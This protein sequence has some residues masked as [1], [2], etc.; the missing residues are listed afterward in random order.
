MLGLQCE[1]QTRSEQK[2][3]W[4]P[5]RNVNSIIYDRWLTV[6]IALAILNESETRIVNLA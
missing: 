6:A 3:S 1:S 4:Q 5:I 2:Q